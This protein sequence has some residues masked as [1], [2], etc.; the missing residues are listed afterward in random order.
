MT[1]SFPHSISIVLPAFNEEESIEKAVRDAVEFLPSFF[2]SF[3]VIVVDDGSSDRTASIVR[4]LQQ[5]LPEVVLVKHPRNLGYGR[6]LANGFAAATKDIVFF[7]DADNQFDIAELK[8]V[9]P[10]LEGLGAV[11]GFRAYRYDSVLRCI[12]SWVY[13]RM[14]RVLFMVRVRDVDCSFKLFW[15]KVIQ[16]IPIEC[17]DFFVDTEIVARIARSGC[18][19][20]E[21]AVKHLPRT[22]GKTTVRASHIPRTLMTVARMWFRIHF[23]KPA[24]APEPVQPE[25]SPG[26]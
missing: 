1:V 10:E 9:A 15:R 17:N 23:C 8:H 11:F 7:T 5:S 13:N 2:P 21:V 19:T 12:T 14:V 4:G 25:V 16:E 22:A 6:A 26:R 18:K 20:K 3:E 24:P